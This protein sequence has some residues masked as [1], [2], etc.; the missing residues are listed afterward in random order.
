M[1]S[2][3]GLTSEEELFSQINSSVKLQ[4]KINLPEGLSELEIQKELYNLAKKNLNVKDS[5]SFL[6]GG[7]YNR[8]IPSCVDYI[9]QRSEFLTPYTPYQ[10]EISQ[11]ILQAIYEYQSLICNLTGMDVTNA[12]M[13]DGAT[14]CAEAI[15]MAVRIT[16][17]NKALISSTLNPNYQ[18]VIE[19]YLYAAN[20]PLEFVS[21]ENGKTNIKDLNSKIE[22][23]ACFLI[24]NPNYL[25]CL[26]K[27]FEISEI[28]KSTDSKFIV[29]VDPVSLGILK[30]P[31]CYG[32]DI[33]TG[34]IQP[35][36]TSM[37]LG[38]PHCGFIACKQ[39][40]VRQMPGRIVGMT[41]N[42]DGERAF[43][44]TLQSREQHIRR[45]KATS[46]I[47]SNQALIALRTAIYLSIMGY[48]GLKQI[49][50]ISC[51]RARF[52][53][54]SIKK[55]DGFSI[56]FADFLNEFVIKIDKRIS[57]ADFL[58]EM[59]KKNILAG[60]DLGKKYAEFENCLLV[61]V[62]E[63]NE[64]EHLNQF[65]S[66]IKSYSEKLKAKI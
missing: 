30:S 17:K 65:I 62:T 57:L 38:G 27:V 59:K 21:I 23:S 52:L 5:I 49:N 39:D 53:A 43:T 63:M 44:L 12:G 46:N 1:L 54:E 20:I 2:E 40:Y 18:K 47:C 22:N 36:G 3:I 64:P 60:I 15:L 48:E 24:Q 6:G 25:G 33:V 16:K 31:S 26:E 34:D 51:E 66:A 37:S 29:C 58:T 28:C 7:V 55:I 42:K 11:G 50:E 45:E 32:A 8:F 10:P 41:I 14:A 13:Y 9:S 61:C 56:V 4:K 19:S 35:L